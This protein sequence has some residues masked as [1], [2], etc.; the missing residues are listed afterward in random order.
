MRSL[1]K[2]HDKYIY[3]LVLGT[4]NLAEDNFAMFLHENILTKGLKDGNGKEDRVIPIW[5][6][7]DCRYLI[8]E[9]SIIK[10]FE[11]YYFVSDPTSRCAKRYIEF[12]KRTVNQGR[13]KF[14]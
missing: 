1:E 6:T 4:Q 13:K 14:K 2:L 8:M 10:G 3:I 9:F 5:V 11:Y 12:V 7:N